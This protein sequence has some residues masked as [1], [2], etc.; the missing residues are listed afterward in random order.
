MSALE[1]AQTKHQSAAGDVTKYAL[2]RDKALDALIRAELRYR[3]AIK[4]VARSQKR[5]DRLREEARAVR[6]ARAA[7]R[8]QEQSKPTEVGGDILEALGI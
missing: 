4:A 6:A 1:R 2:K 7:R 3:K 8:V 5:Y